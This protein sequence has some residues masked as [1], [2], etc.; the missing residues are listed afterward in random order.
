MKK[1]NIPNWIFINLV[2]SGIIN[3]C[4][5]FF[6]SIRYILHMVLSE[7]N[8]HIEVAGMDATYSLN[9]HFT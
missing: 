9:S 6:E 7:S 5:L 3:V 2:I 8:K 1:L 4:I